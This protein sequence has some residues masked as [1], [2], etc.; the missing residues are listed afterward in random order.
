MSDE[1]TEN[2]FDRD[3]FV[4]WRELAAMSWPA[5]GQWCPRHWAPASC[6]EFNGVGASID[7]MS[8][9]STTTDS[10]DP[11]GLTAAMQQ[12]I[13]ENGAIC[14]T[15]GDDKMQQIWNDWPVYRRL[16]GQVDPES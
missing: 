7:M 5:N 4:R 14:C 8:I 15:L 16:E 6:G 2:F 10:T 11:A 3:A 12:A 13:N 9:W 1:T